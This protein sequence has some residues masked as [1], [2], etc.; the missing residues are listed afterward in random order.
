[1]VA[2]GVVAP[3]V[4]KR[5][6]A[7]A[8]L[9][10]A[11]AFS[12]PLGLCVAV[13]RSRGRDVATCA[14]QMWAY[15]AMY[16]SPHDDADAQKRRVRIDYPIVADRIL[17]LG[18]LPTVRL[19]RTLARNGGVA[20]D[21]SALDRVLVW[22]HWSWFIVPHGSL[23][24]I[25]V[26]HRAR[27]PRAAVLMYAVF[28]IGASAYW[29]IPTAPPWYAA[30]VAAASISASSSEMDDDASLEG[31]R[32]ERSLAVRRMMVEYGELFWRDGWGSL[33]SVFGGNPLAAMPSLHFA[34]SVMAA[35]LLAEVGPVAGALG[36]SYAAT[37]GFALVY[38]GE[39]Y[40]VDLLA[41]AALT[42][43]V[44]RLGPRAVPAV[45][46][47]GRAVATLEEMAHEVA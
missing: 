37:L 3:L 25:L 9:V 13:R 2:A 7:P 26:R 19:Q 5:V 16:K 32:G 29:L 40:V 1:M 38:L 36:F 27:F 14:L 28:D 15:L 12:A 18:E 23:A 17:G 30:E 45:A 24:Y 41:G 46:R 8:L 10:Q 33:Y 34:T 4:R 42:I 6:D 22:A 21:W 39:H 35:L 43:A 20:A 11:V 31:E 44:R 47:V